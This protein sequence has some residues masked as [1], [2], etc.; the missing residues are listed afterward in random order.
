MGTIY[1]ITPTNSSPF[2]IRICLG[3]LCDGCWEDTNED[4]GLVLSP[5]SQQLLLF[6]MKRDRR[7]LLPDGFKTWQ[8]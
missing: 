2:S 6:Y 3:G 4:G 5:N 8:K 7:A 1:E